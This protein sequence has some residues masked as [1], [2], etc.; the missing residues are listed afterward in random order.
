MDHVQIP[1]D[2]DATNWRL[3]CN[4]RIRKLK[5]QQF[6]AEDQPCHSPLFQEQLL[7][8]ETFVSFEL[9]EAVRNGDAESF[10]DILEK[11][12]AQKKLSL[13][14]ILEQVTRAGSSLLHVAAH[15]GSEKIA[16]L[17]CQHFPELLSKR[18]IKGD[19]AIHVAARAKNLNLMK[20]ILAQYVAEKSKYSV[21]NGDKVEELP[22]IKNEYGNTALHE[23]VCCNHFEG[24]AC[25]FSAEQHVA[26]CL[27]KLGKSPLYLSVLAPDKEILSLLLQAPFKKGEP[28]PTSRGNSPLHAAILERNSGAY[29]SIL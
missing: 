6:S 14:A 20:I 10:V 28:L 9:F 11:V 2:G 24:V 17:I 4:E 12:S 29:E 26:H 16:E 18:N 7:S 15:F 3:R 1:I 19:T 8:G 5:A 23:A 21:E 13:L 25:L 27:N 22:R